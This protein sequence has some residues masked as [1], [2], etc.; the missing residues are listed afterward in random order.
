MYSL[1]TI[2][3]ARVLNPRALTFVLLYNPGKRNCVILAILVALLLLLI[4]PFMH[5]ITTINHEYDGVN[6]RHLLKK[7]KHD[8][9]NKIIIGHLNIISIR[10]KFEFLKEI[11]GNNIDIFLVSE[12]KLDAT[13]PSGQCLINGYYVP[14]RLYR[15]DNGDGLLLYF[16]DHIPCKKITIDFR[17]VLE[18]IVIEINLKKGNGC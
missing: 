5:L 2:P 13:F 11:I 17:P 12:T 4:L 8:N 1:D 18:A 16:R 3:T 15:N 6:P 10:L 9:H 7:L 14:F